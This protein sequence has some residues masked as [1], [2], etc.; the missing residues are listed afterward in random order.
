MN[1]A[2]TGAARESDAADGTGVVAGAA[3]EGG[4]DPGMA[5]AVGEVTVT[6]APAQSMRCRFVESIEGTGGESDFRFTPLRTAD[7]EAVASVDSGVGTAIGMGVGGGE[8]AGNA[9][10][11]IAGLKR[12]AGGRATGTPG[13]DSSATEGIDR[14]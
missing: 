8:V 13:D 11:D 6:A 4:D 10:F 14:L 5:V 3:A 1:G 2:G 12:G 7:G 9:K